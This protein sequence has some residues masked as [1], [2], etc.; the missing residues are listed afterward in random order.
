MYLVDEGVYWGGLHE[1]FI[2]LYYSKQL[3]TQLYFK[4]M[5]TG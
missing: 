4:Y 1:N 3:L 2:S 5:Y